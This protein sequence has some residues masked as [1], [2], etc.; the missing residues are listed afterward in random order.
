MVHTAQDWLFNAIIDLFFIEMLSKSFKCPTP[1]SDN[2][3]CS[4]CCTFM[5]F[6]S[7]I[8]K[9]ATPHTMTV[10]RQII[11]KKDA[12]LLWDRRCTF[13]ENVGHMRCLI[14]EKK[15]C[16]TFMKIFYIYH[17]PEFSWHHAEAANAPF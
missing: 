13:M 14:M 12:N 16:Y 1:M 10:A 6:F 3:Y 5:E 9:C 2:S 8:Y 4:R 15:R 11:A 7:S 17:L